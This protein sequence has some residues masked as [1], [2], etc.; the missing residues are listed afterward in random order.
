MTKFN[1]KKTY[2]NLNWTSLFL[3]LVGVVLVAV[4]TA[5][6]FC[7][8][9]GNDAVSVLFAGISNRFNINLGIAVYLINAIAFLISLVYGRK[10]IG[11]GTIMYI[12]LTGRII[13][14]IVLV[15][16]QF[17][18]VQSLVFRVICAIFGSLVM[19]FGASLMVFSRTGADVWTAMAITIADSFNKDF[20][21]VKVVIDCAMCLFGFLLGGKV[22]VVTITVSLFGAPLLK[23]IVKK[24]EKTK[25][26]LN[27]R[28]VIDSNM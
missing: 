9:L 19:I 18:P 17:S 6:N 5:I 4:G 8:N 21:K 14:A 23:F 20:R 11:I 22:G 12:F 10:N 15:Y 26:R 7:A 28:Q 16:N 2:K 24:L 25:I 1:L 13:D 3:A 27:K